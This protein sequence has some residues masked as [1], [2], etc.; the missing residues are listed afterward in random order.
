MGWEMSQRSNFP[1]RNQILFPLL[2]SRAGPRDRWNM[3]LLWTSLNHV[4]DASGFG[5]TGCFILFPQVAVSQLDS[6]CD[7]GV[8]EVPWLCGSGE[9][10]EHV[11]SVDVP[12]LPAV[13]PL[14][15]WSVD[16]VRL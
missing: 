4:L 11:V 15:G 6:G 16:P 9:L 12:C 3:F 14:Y 1:L 10:E 7:E 5:L 2:Y 8:V 13:V